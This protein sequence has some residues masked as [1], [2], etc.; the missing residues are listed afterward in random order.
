MPLESMTAF[1]GHF[2]L[3]SS[4]QAY[5]FSF[6]QSSTNTGHVGMNGGDVVGAGVVVGTTV[7]DAGLIADDTDCGETVVE[8]EVE[9]I[10]LGVGAF[11]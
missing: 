2:N 1:G 3:F 10:V 4:L 7:V 6:Q 9:R 11:P 8:I 5:F